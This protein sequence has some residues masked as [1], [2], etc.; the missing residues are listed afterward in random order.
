MGSVDSVRF[1]LCWLEKVIRGFHK[2]IPRY[3]NCATYGSLDIASLFDWIIR[4]RQ[5]KYFVDFY[6]IVASTLFDIKESWNVIGRKTTL[7]NGYLNLIR[8]LGDKGKF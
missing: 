6:L 8:F 3:L 1:K 4:N 2:N 5:I 7:Q